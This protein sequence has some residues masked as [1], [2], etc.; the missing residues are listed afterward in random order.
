MLLL[1]N[2]VSQSYPLNLPLHIPTVKQITKGNPEKMVKTKQNNLKSAHATKPWQK[3]VDY[4][5]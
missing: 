1:K 5:I 2:K 4:V 3:P